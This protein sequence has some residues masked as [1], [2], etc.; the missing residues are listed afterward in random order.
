MADEKE[1]PAPASTSLTDTLED[2]LAPSKL[3]QDSELP[4]LMD[5]QMFIRFDKLKEKWFP[6]NSIEELQEAVAK[7]STLA[8]NNDKSAV[9]PALK[10]K[11]TVV[12]IREVPET[13]QASDL[14]ELLSKF[15]AKPDILTH[16]KDLHRDDNAQMWFANFEE[17]NDAMDV[18][19]WLQ[20]QKAPWGEGMVRCAMKSDHVVRSFFPA[21]MIPPP[22]SMNPFAPA[23]FLPSQFVMPHMFGPPL[24][25]GMMKGKGKGIPLMND[26]GKMGMMKGKGKGIPMFNEKGKGK[27]KKGPK[28]GALGPPSYPSAGGQDQFYG[29]RPRQPSQHSAVSKEFTMDGRPNPNFGTKEALQEVLHPGGTMEIQDFGD[30]RYQGHFQKYTREEIL[31]ICDKMEAVQKPD[32]FTEFEKE[33]EN[34]SG[35]FAM[36]ANST[37]A[38]E[39]TDNVHQYPSATKSQPQKQQNNR[40]TKG[41]NGK[42]DAE[43]VAGEE[44]AAGRNGQGQ[45]EGAARKGKKK[46]KAPQDDAANVNNVSTSTKKKGKKAAAE[47]YDEYADWNG[48]D[49][50]D[51]NSN[52]W[53]STGGVE[54]RRKKTGGQTHVKD[55]GGAQRPTWKAKKA[56]V[57]AEVTDTQEAA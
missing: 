42:E 35:I 9:K 49:E 43:K 25:M 50:G 46:Q 18:A 17:E 54:Y 13:V 41:K 53:A 23:Q 15:E 34:V 12:I 30:T 37:W 14:R 57:A 28:L 51:W 48:W 44:E 1:A 31:E 10:A 6:Q 55:G 11:R 3:G 21:N 38:K 40:R 33:N 32:T 2:M 16:L 26:K 52:N 47:E 22:M 56:E 29:Q 24:Y 8:M 5:A 4:K 20:R 45:K 27:G 36:E 39:N 19:I 7:S